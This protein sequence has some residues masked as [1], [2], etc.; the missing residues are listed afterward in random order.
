MELLAKKEELTKQY[1]RV[2]ADKRAESR[3]LTFREQLEQKVKDQER[4]AKEELDRQ[5]EL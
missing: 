1:N 3:K 5:A 2:M 4:E